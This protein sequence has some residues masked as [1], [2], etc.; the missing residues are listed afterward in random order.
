MKTT[1]LFGLINDFRLKCKNVIDSEVGLSDIEMYVCNGYIQLSFEND[2][3]VINCELSPLDDDLAL[4][5]FEVI[6]D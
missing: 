5:G 1:K 4:T 3:V 2:D 6:E